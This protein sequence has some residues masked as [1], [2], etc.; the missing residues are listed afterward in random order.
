MVWIPPDITNT[1]ENRDVI[2][3]FQI[4]SMMSQSLKRAFTG[5]AG[6]EHGELQ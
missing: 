4:L 5:L 6:H 1:L 2:K 3:K